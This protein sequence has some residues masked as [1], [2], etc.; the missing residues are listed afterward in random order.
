VSPFFV[1]FALFMTYPLLYS[2][3]ISLFET[4]GL[5]SKVF[6]GFDNFSTL[7][8]DVLFWKSVG[9]TAYFAAGTLALQLP[10]ALLLAVIL[11]SKLIKGRSG[12][13]LA[14]FSP[15]LV[16]G[17]FVAIIFN[18]IYN[19]EFGLLNQLLRTIGFSSDIR[20]LQDSRLVM[21]AIILAGVWRWSGYNMIFFLAGLQ[22]IRQEL[23]EA[24]AVDGAGSWRKFVHV[25]IPGLRPMLVFVLIT[26][27]IGSF[28]LFDLPMVMTSATGSA[29][30][31]PNN[32]AMTIVMYLYKNGFQFMRLGY[33][34]A[35]GWVLV[36][37]IVL[38]SLIQ[39]R[40]LGRGQSV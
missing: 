29:I 27:M 31:G 28:Q 18:H 34:A 38:I 7:L 30:G 20:W 4:R 17:V 39:L 19:R 32:A 1:L 40:L 14:F 8:G 24:A 37:I 2:I 25:T 36:I 12:F 13:R 6:I 35:I 33:A 15:V 9:N 10:L 3:W 23:Y 26:S 21:P 16:A 11:N 5:R 22:S